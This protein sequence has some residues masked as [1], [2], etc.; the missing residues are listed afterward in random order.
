MSAACSHKGVNYLI[1]AMDADSP[2]VIIDQPFPM[3][4]AF[5]KTFCDL[6]RA[7]A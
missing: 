7:N 1:E 2:L 3:H 4:N 5:K 6:Q